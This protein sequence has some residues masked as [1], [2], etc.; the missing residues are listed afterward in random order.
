MRKSQSKAA[1][2]VT[3]DRLDIEILRCLLGDSRRPVSSI[4]EDV[5]VSESTVRNRLKKLVSNGLVNFGVT[6]DPRKFGHQVWAMLE[7]NVELPKIR[8]VADRISMEPR[9]HMV[10]ITSGAYDIF[11]ATVLRSNEDLID[12]IA[13][14]LSKIPGITRVSSSTILEMVKRR[15]DFGFPEA[16]YRN[17]REPS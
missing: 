4:A 2:Q 1:Q 13:N 10:G 14:R 5:R 9:V 7:I 12:L 3:A 16:V 11:A 6:T 15:T 17:R 8:S